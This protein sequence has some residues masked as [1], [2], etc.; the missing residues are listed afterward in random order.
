MSPDLKTQPAPQFTECVS[1]DDGESRA[2]ATDSREMGRR[3]QELIEQIQT[4]SNPAA[5]TLLQECL[6]SLLAFYGEG[7]SRILDQIHANGPDGKKILDRLLKDPTIS[8]LLLIHGLHPVPLEMRLRGALEKVRPYMQSHGGNIELLS[9]ENEVAQIRLQGTCKTC[10]SSA[11]TLELAVRR[12]VEE[13][14][15]D[16]AGF[17]VLAEAPEPT[18]VAK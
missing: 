1:P 4:Q 8:A 3:L 13:A 10:P 2:A 9:L 14:C 6:Q 18:A 12:A 15:P 7:L 11:V 17:E 16:L 5:R